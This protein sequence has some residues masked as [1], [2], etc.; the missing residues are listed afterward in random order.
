M[1]VQ[2]VK[3]YPHSKR[4]SEND[5]WGI[6]YN[7]VVLGKTMEESIPYVTKKNHSL[8]DSVSFNELMR[9]ENDEFGVLICAIYTDVNLYLSS[10]EDEF[11]L[12]TE[13]TD[14]MNKMFVFEYMIYPK[15]M[16]DTVY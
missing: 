3:Y 11:I 13:V 10:H 12:P 8:I 7:L 2:S 1:R 16:E 4:Q 14:D 9:K 5:N 6:L 15:G